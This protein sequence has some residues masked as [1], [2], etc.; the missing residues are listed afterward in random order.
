[1]TYKEVVQQI[2]DLNTIQGLVNI[3]QQVAAMRMRKI[4]SN[5]TR[6]REFYTELLDV[7]IQA[8]KAYVENPARTAGGTAPQ[9]KK[10]RL[11]LVM[12]A[13]T[14]LY[15][16]IVKEV[17]D[18]FVKENLNPATKTSQARD[19][20]VAGRLGRSWMAS[21]ED[22]RDY[23]YFDLGDGATNLAYQLKEIFSYAGQYRNILVYH[24]V[25]KSITE[26]VP[27]VTTISREAKM[28]NTSK[29][30]AL[31]DET[32]IFEPT[33]DQ[34]L[35]TFEEQFR[36]T[37]FDQSAYESALA[38]FGSRMVSL[39]S[40]VQNITK[41]LTKNTFT[42]MKIRHREL[43]KKQINNLLGVSQWKK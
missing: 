17:F 26:Q 2:S 16:S 29:S 1:M 5:V 6:T 19:L 8:Q 33:L 25:F 30:S 9:Q 15:G 31:K 14:G 21:Q 24:G 13:N 18:L 23:K 22:A 20:A 12:T 28:A 43:N 39:D 34:V 10:D 27:T 35:E 40:A 42:S 37:F 3:Y 11:A 41:E 4:K 32:Y 36:H 7:Y 38:K